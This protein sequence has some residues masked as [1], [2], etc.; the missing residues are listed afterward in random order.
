[1]DDG[2][3]KRGF[4]NIEK[5]GE[6]AAKSLSGG[7]VLA[8]AAAAAAVAAVAAVFRKGISEASEAE[9]S[10]TKFNL[11]LR[12]SGIFSAEASNAFTDFSSKLQAQTGISDDLINSN[13]ALLVSIG[14]LSGEGLQRAT[15]AAID[16]SAATGKDLNSSFELVAKAA[17]GNTEAFG[18]YGIKIDESIPKTQRYAAVLG[19]MEQKFG[20]VAS[21]LASSTFSGAVSKFNV[22]LNDI[23]ES[24]GNLI[25]KSPVIRV[26]LDY[27]AK[28][29]AQIAKAI[30]SVGKTD[31]IGSAIKTLT[32]I[33][34]SFI[35]IVG[36]PIEIFIR[37][38]ITGLRTIKFGFD[39]LA[40][41]V[42]GTVK[43]IAT[44]TKSLTP[45]I[46]AEFKKVSDIATQSWENLSASAETNWNTNISSS[47]TQ[48]VAT[49]S[50]EIEKAKLANNSFAENTGLAS[51]EVVYEIQTLG[52]AFS[53]M[54]AGFN[55]ESENLAKNAAKYFQEIGKSAVKGLG[56]S[57]GNAFAAFG[58]ALATG[59]NAL[60][61]FFNTFIAS[62]GNML[63]QA[64]A[65]FIIEGIALSLL[66]QPNGPPLIA[67]GAAMSVLGGVMSAVGGG[68]KPIAGSSEG[69]GVAGGIG[70]TFGQPSSTDLVQSEKAKP[71]TNIEVNIA[72]D[73]L[74]SDETG[75]RIVDIINKAFDKQGV[76][77]NGAVA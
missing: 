51:T 69:G 11:A 35:Q 29:F 22:A 43:L 23:F 4:A 72:G 7:F 59:E 5:A 71:G 16:F 46:E 56:N 41:G 34:L 47:I 20:G 77:I 17:A 52:Q 75:I 67:A 61:S 74:D 62:I 64:G 68:P 28:A 8:A 65:A 50:A 18:R 42:I 10:L 38:L 2:S 49:Y 24:I 30:E 58:R 21:T 31:I 15:K 44:V 66:Y 57:V 26:T 63:I 55:E 9:A 27:I 6:D 32:E 12:N 36:P 45:E 53:A 40:L 48:G 33:F 19:L 37:S 3:I 25:V 54:A 70:G 73:V 39:L 13:A 60:D 1:M 76:T 14:N